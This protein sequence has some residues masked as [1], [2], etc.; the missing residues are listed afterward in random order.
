MISS[1]LVLPRTTPFRRL[2]PSSALAELAAS[3]SRSTVE[4]ASLTELMRPTSPSAVTTG[5]PT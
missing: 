4:V 3:L 1:P 2:V 5:I